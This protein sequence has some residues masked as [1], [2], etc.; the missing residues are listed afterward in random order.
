MMFILILDWVAETSPNFLSRP[1]MI[2]YR[3]LTSFRKYEYFTDHTKYKNN[4]DYNLTLL[5][6]NN[7]FYMTNDTIILYENENIFSPVSQLNYNFYHDQNVI[8]NDLKKNEN[9]QCIIGNNELP[10]GEAQQPGLFDYADGEDVMEF[11]LRI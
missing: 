10:F 1:V 2:L 4:Y 7:K 9:I 11:L 6:M 5:I 8:I 3:C